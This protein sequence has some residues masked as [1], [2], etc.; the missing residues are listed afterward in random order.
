MAKHSVPR[1]LGNVSHLVDIYTQ[2]K[3]KR[4]GRAD[5][6]NV[7]TCVI[8]FLLFLIRCT[9]IDWGAGMHATLLLHFAI[10]QILVRSCISD[11]FNCV[12]L[13]CGQRQS[14]LN[15]ISNMQVSTKDNDMIDCKRMRR[16]NVQTIR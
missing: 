8:F 12:H 6:L 16:S 10:L 11:L 7:T 3:K 14:F 5:R 4:G 15:G 2:N 1:T 9:P 13:S